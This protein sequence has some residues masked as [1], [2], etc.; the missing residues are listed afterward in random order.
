MPEEIVVSK[1]R[2]AEIAEVSPG[3]VSQWLAAGKVHGDAIVGHGHRA[4]IRVPVALE[5]LPVGSTRYS[6]SGPLAVPRSTAMV[7]LAHPIAMCL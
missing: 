6:T 5:Q 2:F 4:R 7:K 3:C 1:K